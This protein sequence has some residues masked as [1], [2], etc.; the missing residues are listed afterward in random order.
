MRLLVF[1]FLISLTNLSIA[2]KK[3]WINKVGEEVK[4]DVATSYYTFSKTPTK[5][6]VFKKF[7]KATDSLYEE[8]NYP[9]KERLRK[10]GKYKR[11]SE[12]G[13]LVKEGIYLNDSQSGLWSYYNESGKLEKT[14][15]F[16]LGIKN[17]TQVDY[18][19]N[20]IIEAVYQYREGSLNNLI[21]LFD[22]EGNSLFKK[23]TSEIAVYIFVDEEAIFPGGEKALELFI[24]KQL[25]TTKKGKT[26]VFV[27]FNI[28]KDGFV[29]EIEVNKL[30]N[31]NTSEDHIK[32]VL[33]FIAIMPQWEPAMK[34]G[35][36]VK[37]KQE[38]VIVMN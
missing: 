21:Q 34:R 10:E 5:T 14:I 15:T 23:D 6:Y 27:S 32:Q 12:N 25:P 22:E 8:V 13:K 33:K 18:N 4:K 16:N 7:L 31:S 35:R 36:L 38:L 24:K 37:S 30:T 19:K 29:S 26:K 3:H 11:Y 20:Q 9:T 17:G 2:Q 1:I 28:N